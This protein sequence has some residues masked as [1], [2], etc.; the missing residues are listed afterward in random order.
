[1]QSNHA[2]CRRKCV[3]LL[4]LPPRFED[5][6]SFCSSSALPVQLPREFWKLT[7]TTTKSLSPTSVW[8]TRGR[9]WATARRTSVSR[10]SKTTM[11]TTVAARWQVKLLRIFKSSWGEIGVILHTFSHTHTHPVSWRFPFPL[12]ISWWRWIFVKKILRCV[13]NFYWTLMFGCVFDWANDDDVDL[14]TG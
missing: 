8:I 12:F 11:S 14:C 1:M 3:F 5:Y 13:G 4:S 9:P 6:S 10:C 7:T 2:R